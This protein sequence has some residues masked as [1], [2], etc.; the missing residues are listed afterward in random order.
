MISSSSS[1]SSCSSSLLSSKD[2]SFS[3]EFLRSCVKDNLHIISLN[4]KA[5]NEKDQ[6]KPYVSARKTPYYP[7]SSLLASPLVKKKQSIQEK[8]EN[9]VPT[10]K[11]RA[12]ASSPTLVRQKSFRKEPNYNPVLPNRALRSP[13]PSRRFNNGTSENNSCRRQIV[14]KGNNVKRESFRAPTASPNRD[15]TIGR[16]FLAMKKD[17]LISQQV[18]GKIDDDHVA[19]GDIKGRQDMDIVMEDINNPLIALDCFIFL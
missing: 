7:P 18:S 2:R 14:S 8:A 11:K 12:R 19:A 10:P 16:N 17:T 9:N 15:L 5:I 3:N 6:E 1:L 13:S 4:P